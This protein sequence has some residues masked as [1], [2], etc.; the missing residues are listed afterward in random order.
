MFNSVIQYFSNNSQFP[1]STIIDFKENYKEKYINY[2][3]DTLVIKQDHF[4]NGLLQDY[5]LYKY[6]VKIN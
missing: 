2:F 3:K 5:R 6:N 1:D 4:V